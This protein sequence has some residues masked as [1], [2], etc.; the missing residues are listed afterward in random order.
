MF[1]DCL[2][3]ES[4]YRVVFGRFQAKLL[5]CPADSALEKIKGRDGRLSVLKAIGEEQYYGCFQFDYPEEPADWTIERYIAKTEL[6][7]FSVRG[8]KATLR[9]K[10]GHAYIFD[11]SDVGRKNS[12]YFKEAKAV[13][14]PWNLVCF[15]PEEEEPTVYGYILNALYEDDR[16]QYDIYSPCPPLPFKELRMDA[17]IYRSIPENLIR[18]IEDAREEQAIFR[19]LMVDP[20]RFLPPKSA[21]TMPNETELDEIIEGLNE[22]IEETDYCLEH[23]WPENFFCGPVYLGF[24]NIVYT[25]NLSNGATIEELDC[26]TQ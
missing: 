19:K 25:P 26:F 5:Q 2:N 24:P 9:S 18:F 4:P 17:A 16:W 6:C 13:F 12:P 7:T 3:N 1:S 11:L 14:R 15:E 10:Q 22:M 8:N 21:C 23:G 20:P